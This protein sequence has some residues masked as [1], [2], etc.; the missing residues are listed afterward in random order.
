VIESRRRR[1]AIYGLR[2]GRGRFPVSGF[3]FPV[4]GFRFPVSDF[5]P[6]S[7]RASRLLATYFSQAPEK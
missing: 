2:P 1:G 6:I 3:R 7:P 5:K 4:S